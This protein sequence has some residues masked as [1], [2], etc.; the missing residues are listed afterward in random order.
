MMGHAYRSQSNVRKGDATGN[1]WR[2]YPS[3]NGAIVIERSA[4]H[5]VAGSFG[6]LA[7]AAGVEHVAVV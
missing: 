5:Q 2:D 4:K 7:G 6:Q 3:N 1:E